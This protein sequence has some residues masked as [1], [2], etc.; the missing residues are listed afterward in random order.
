MSISQKN[1]RKAIKRGEWDMSFL[2]RRMAKKLRGAP[3]ELKRL[4]KQLQTH[5]VTADFWQKAFTRTRS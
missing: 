1:R 3:N 4:G 5:H 2:Y